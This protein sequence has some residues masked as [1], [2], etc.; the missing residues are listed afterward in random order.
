MTVT[1]VVET[2]AG[3]TIAECAWFTGDQ[4]FHEGDFPVGA[5]KKEEK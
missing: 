2:D 4:I 5:V 1:N 3:V